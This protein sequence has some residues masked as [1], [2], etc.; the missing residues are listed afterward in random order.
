MTSGSIWPNIVVRI[1]GRKR[2]SSAAKETDTTASSA[3][4]CWPAL[5]ASSFCFSPIYWPATAA[6]PVAIAEKI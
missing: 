2:Y 5:Q 3:M 6:P 4:S 1:C